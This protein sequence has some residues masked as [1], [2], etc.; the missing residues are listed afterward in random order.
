M[1]E[2]Y[3]P[4]ANDP[5]RQCVLFEVCCQERVDEEEPRVAPEIEEGVSKQCG[6]RGEVLLLAQSVMSR[7]ACSKQRIG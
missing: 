7:G 3:V 1:Y 2:E 6:Q 5:E 4:I